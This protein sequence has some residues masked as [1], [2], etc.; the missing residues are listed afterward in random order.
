MIIR[1]AQVV[2]LARLRLEIW[3]S[4]VLSRH[5]F[6]GGNGS[7]RFLRPGCCRIARYFPAGVT[8]RRKP[9]APRIAARLLSC[10]L[11][12]LESVR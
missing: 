4:W 5:F 3:A 7:L 2:D 9:V 11:P 1:T 12:R 10:G 8:L 6:P